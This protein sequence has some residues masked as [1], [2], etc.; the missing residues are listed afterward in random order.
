MRDSQVFLNEVRYVGRQRNVWAM[1]GCVQIYRSAS[2]LVAPTS[3][4]VMKPSIFRPT[5]HFCR[6]RRSLHCRRTRGAE[7][8]VTDRTGGLRRRCVDQP[9]CSARPSNRPP[10]GGTKGG[11][12]TAR[13]PKNR[14]NASAKSLEECRALPRWPE[15]ARAESIHDKVDG[16]RGQIVAGSDVGKCFGGGQS[17][18]LNGD[19]NTGGRCRWRN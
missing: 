4:L 18:S 7:N 1:F 2:C 17:P 14:R 19:N 9:T 5:F 10:E 8:S 13:T 12:E 16:L 6:N 15:N 11:G 3:A